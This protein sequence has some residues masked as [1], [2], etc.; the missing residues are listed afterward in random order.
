M[1]KNF[2]SGD[3]VVVLCL[4]MILAAC[5]TAADPIGESDTSRNNLTSMTENTSALEVP[6]SSAQSSTEG[7][8]TLE[9]SGASESQ[10]LIT[11]DYDRECRKIGLYAEA[12]AQDEWE[13]AIRVAKAFVEEREDF[14]KL[15]L[16]G[17]CPDDLWAY[18]E[19]NRA[20]GTVIIFFAEV[21]LE[22]PGDIDRIVLDMYKNEDG[23]WYVTD[24]GK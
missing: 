17:R 23:S 19:R 22:D 5:N 7:E 8:E 13:E 2:Y 18:V 16:L 24:W 15:L 10:P 11:A 4:A 6:S 1:M 9:R 14:K 21:E 3:R 12:L 20:P